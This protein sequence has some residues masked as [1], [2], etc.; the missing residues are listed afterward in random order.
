MP[1]PLDR[2][3]FLAT[4]VLGALSSNSR[5]ADRTQLGAPAPSR[6]FVSLPP[7]AVARNTGWPE[8]ARLAARVGYKG[9]DWAFGPAKT[10]GVE[11]TRALL[12]ELG[13]APTICNLP[14]QNALGP[15]DAA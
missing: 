2:R 1:G 12:A 15:D 3:Q 5:N 10:A 14:M 7:W 4:T 8:Q 6:M 11:A 9:I 13:I